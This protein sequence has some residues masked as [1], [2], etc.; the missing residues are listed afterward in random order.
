MAEEELC[1]LTFGDLPLLD[2]VDDMEDPF[3][4][5]FDDGFADG[6]FEDDAF[7]GFSP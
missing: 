1:E 3:S 5:S 7:Q 2:S 6:D 4:S